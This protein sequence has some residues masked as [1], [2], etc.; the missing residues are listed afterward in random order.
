[1]ARRVSKHPAAKPTAA[2]HPAAKHPAAKRTAK[3]AVGKAKK[4][5]SPHKPAVRAAPAT[6]PPAA[7]SAP[8]Q[9]AWRAGLLAEMSRGLERVDET[10]AH[11]EPAAKSRSRGKA[12]PHE[13]R[14]SVRSALEQLALQIKPRKDGA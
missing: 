10:L 5:A 6:S 8:R 7:A 9:P 4:A 12:A 14:D 13:L 1:M 2:K 11:A 3:P